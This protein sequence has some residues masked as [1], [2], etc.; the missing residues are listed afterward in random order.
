M[1]VGLVGAAWAVLRRRRRTR[2]TV[3]VGFA[4]GSEMRLDDGPVRDRL[5]EAAR[6]AL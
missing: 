6:R 5:V 3:V 4:D 2:D 1:L